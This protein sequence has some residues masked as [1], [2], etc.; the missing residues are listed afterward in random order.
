MRV[1]L[2]AA[3]LVR[4]PREMRHSGWTDLETVADPREL[5]R[6][7]KVKLQLRETVKRRQTRKEG[8]CRCGNCS[9]LSQLLSECG[10]CLE[11]LQTRGGVYACEAC[12]HAACGACAL[13]LSACPFCRGP[14]AP[15]RCVALERLVAEVALP[16][17]FARWGCPTQ[18]T[19]LGRLLH[20][21]LCAFC[22]ERDA[23]AAARSPSLRRVNVVAS[24]AITIDI[25]NFRAKVL[26]S[27]R[28]KRKYE[29]EL[30]CHDAAFRCRIALF[31][32]NLRMAF[33]RTDDGA[34]TRTFG[35]WLDIR[36]SFKN[37]TGLLPIAQNTRVAKVL[38]VSCDGLLSPLWNRRL[39]NGGD[40]EERVEIDISI[41]PL[42]HKI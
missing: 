19:A 31:R 18:T 42:V 35:A 30:I 40:R 9:R 4:K 24:D 28:R 10:V 22:P 2:Q 23:A 29:V 37:L 38:D 12:G 14:S 6:P 27:D 20:E 7:S 39:G 3:W 13:R 34:T 26:R 41:R 1:S 21:A 16:C 25:A 11:P 5:P 32:R 36:S 8:H 17:R 15:R 33:L